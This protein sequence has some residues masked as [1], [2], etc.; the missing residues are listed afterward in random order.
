M[1]A[2]RKRKDIA[3]SAWTMVLSIWPKYIGMRRPESGARSLSQGSVLN[4]TMASTQT[5]QLVVCVNN[6]GYPASLEKRK[7]YLALPDAAA[8]KHGLLRV[9]DESSEDYL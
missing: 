1:G 5:Q 6:E 3:R 7:I 2:G 8:G 4:D 9:V